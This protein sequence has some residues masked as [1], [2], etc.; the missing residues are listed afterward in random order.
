MTN[1]ESLYSF[2]QFTSIIFTFLFTNAL[3]CKKSVIIQYSQHAK[4]TRD[5]K[6]KSRGDKLKN[7]PQRNA[8]EAKYV[9]LRDTQ[10]SSSTY[11]TGHKCVYR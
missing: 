4:F 1:A 10:R 9:T 11:Y 6:E 8:S 3:K 2:T 5:N 7:L